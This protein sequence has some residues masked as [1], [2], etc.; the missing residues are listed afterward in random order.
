PEPNAYYDSLDG[1]IEAAYQAVASRTLEPDYYYVQ[2]SGLR[3]FYPAFHAQFVKRL[4][5]FS[6]A[7]QRLDVLDGVGRG[8]SASGLVA[9]QQSA[10][11][12][13]VAALTPLARQAQ[14][15]ANELVAQNR[16]SFASTRKLLMGV[17]AGSLALALTLG[18]LISWSLVVPLR[19]TGTRMSEIA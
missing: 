7:Q 4:A 12:W 11:N 18:L 8:A 3:R 6:L 15:R 1:T 19:Q 14:S 10:S 2:G 5:T 17:S 16:S 9:R 13:L